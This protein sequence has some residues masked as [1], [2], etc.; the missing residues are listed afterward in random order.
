MY[1]VYIPWE[2]QSDQYWNELCARVVE[3]FGLP[4]GKY[5]SHPETDW[6][7]FSFKDERDHLMCKML[8]SEH[9]AERKSWEL[10]VEE[11]PETGDGIL[12]FP[13]DLL[14]SAGWQEGD[15]LEWVDLKN[16]SWQLKKKSV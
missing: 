11:D 4:G 5:T 12:T 13:T 2:K 1:N 7:T 9:V 6:M 16:G 8:L 10:T 3:H 14:K 15:V